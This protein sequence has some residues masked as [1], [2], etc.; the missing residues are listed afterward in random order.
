MFELE[1]H[2][3][4]NVTPGQMVFLNAQSLSKVLTII[5]ERWDCGVLDNQACRHVSVGHNT[6][7]TPK[8]RSD[9]Q[10]SDSVIR[11]DERTATLH[12]WKE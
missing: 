2:I 11:D 8:N 5:V 6:V 7:T 3:Y 10:T 12:F 4:H 1:N 9:I